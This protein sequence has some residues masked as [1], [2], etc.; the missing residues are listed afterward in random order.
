MAFNPAAMV[1]MKVCEV[2]TRASTELL[3]DLGEQKAELAQ[4]CVA[5][6]SGGAASKMAINIV[7]IAEVQRSGGDL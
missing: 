4:L 6:V 7:R 3:E 2:R 5:T 1:N